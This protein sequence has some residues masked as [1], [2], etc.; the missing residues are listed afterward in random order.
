MSVV[1]PYKSF[2]VRDGERMF[3]VS[4]LP[5]LE[6]CDRYATIESNDGQVR[7]PSFRVG[8]LTQIIPRS[9]TPDAAAGSDPVDTAACRSH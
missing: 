6:G 3:M 4:I 1:H 5:S 9:G 8:H 7:I 2:Q